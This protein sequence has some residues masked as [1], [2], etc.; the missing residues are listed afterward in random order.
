MVK[1]GDVSF[2]DGCHEPPL[3]IV[4]VPLNVVELNEL[5]RADWL[6]EKTGEN[7]D[8]DDFR[9]VALKK[10]SHF[11]KGKKYRSYLKRMMLKLL[12]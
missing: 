9:E 12:K 5:S 3:C 4:S 11:A 6:A 1:Y 8:D 2:T 10:H 7:D